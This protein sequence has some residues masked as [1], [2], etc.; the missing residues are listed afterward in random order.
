[1]DLIKLSK[2][3]EEQS[4]NLF[5]HPNQFPSPEAAWF[6]LLQASRR[7]HQGVQTSSSREPP[8]PSQCWSLP[9]ILSLSFFHLIA[10]LGGSQE[11]LIL[12]EKLM[13][14]ED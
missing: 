2:G 13:P 8:N 3:A 9:C 1:M 4:E 5:S 14:R 10:Y 12:Q 11:P 6:P 7:F